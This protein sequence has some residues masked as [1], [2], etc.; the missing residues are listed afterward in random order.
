MCL[1]GARSVFSG[2]TIEKKI[3]QKIIK[4]EHAHAVLLSK[5][6]YIMWPAR[7][8][9]VMWQQLG[10]DLGPGEL[11][12]IGF[13]A[14]EDG[15]DEI[16][17]LM[18]FRTMTIPMRLRMLM[19][20][21]EVLGFGVAEWIKMDPKQ[22]QVILHLHNMPVIDEGKQLYGPNSLVSHHY[23][24]IFAVHMRKELGVE[25]ADLRET[26]SVAKG[27]KFSE[28]VTGVKFK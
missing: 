24:G 25:N 6:H 11:Y 7:S 13:K 9:A 5:L 12:D 27:S 26:Q 4:I 1:C 8:F 3:L 23:M 16:I 18:G 28:W 15:A 21:F 17:N 2:T 10:E 20:M 22:N 19:R 14:G